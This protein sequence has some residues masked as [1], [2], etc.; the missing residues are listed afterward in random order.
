M[1][2][3]FDPEKWLENERLRVEMRRRSGELSPDA[4]D[5]ALAELERRYDEMLARLDGTF[6]VAGR[7]GTK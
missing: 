7:N 5:Q 1:T 4:A 6:P 3:N 2:Y